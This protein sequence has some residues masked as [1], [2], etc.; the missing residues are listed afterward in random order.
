MKTRAA[1]LTGLAAKELAAAMAETAITNIFFIIS[2]L[3]QCSN[4]VEPALHVEERNFRRG[5][6]IFFFAAAM[7]SS[8]HRSIALTR[9]ASAGLS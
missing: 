5:R 1:A 3:C 7:S 8:A 9:P 4:R 6:F 2:S